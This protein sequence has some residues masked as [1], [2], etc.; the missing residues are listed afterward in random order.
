MRAQA[1]GGGWRL[2]DQERMLAEQKISTNDMPVLAGVVGIFVRALPRLLLFARL[3]QCGYYGGQRGRVSPGKQA[4]AL[5]RL[6]TLHVPNEREAGLRV[7]LLY[8]DIRRTHENE[9]RDVPIPGALTVS[10]LPGFGV[11]GF[12]KRARRHE[13]STRR[14]GRCRNARHPWSEVSR[15]TITRRYS[16]P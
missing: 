5:S 7:W 9:K 16:E 6:V 14:R 8:A 13:L 12:Q 3:M 11:G 4:P 10:K 1:L 2:R 15:C